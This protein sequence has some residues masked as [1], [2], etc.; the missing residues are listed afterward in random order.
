MNAFAQQTSTHRQ[1]ATLCCTV[2][3][4][5]TTLPQSA[6]RHHCTPP[7]ASSAASASAS[8][9]PSPSLLRRS[10]PINDL[11]D[12][13]NDASKAFQAMSIPFQTMSKSIQGVSKSIQEASNDILSASKSIQKVPNDILSASRFIQRVSND[14]PTVSKSIQRASNDILSATRSIQNVSRCI[15]DKTESIQNQNRPKNKSAKYTDKKAT[16]VQ[17]LAHRSKTTAIE[18]SNRLNRGILGTDTPPPFQS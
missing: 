18:L 2:G 1:G 14:I 11:S 10:T 12:A 15:H 16:I 9:L 17:R 6:L 7:I 3:Q 8:V 5:S 4:I 13:L